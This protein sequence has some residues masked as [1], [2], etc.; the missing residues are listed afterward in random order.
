MEWNEANILNDDIK[1][2]IRKEVVKHQIKWSGFWFTLFSVFFVSIIYIIFDSFENGMLLSVGMLFLYLSDI[3]YFFTFLLIFKSD[4]KR[5]TRL[6][7]NDFKWCVSSVNSVDYI[8]GKVS[9]SKIYTDI[10]AFHTGQSIFRFRK[11]YNVIIVSY[12]NHFSHNELE[13]S[14][15]FLYDPLAY[16]LP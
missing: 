16:I 2:Y 6:D 10:G 13:E 5:L 9:R 1:L 3:I 7:M 14:L 8:G 15:T 4:K 11:Y 12:K